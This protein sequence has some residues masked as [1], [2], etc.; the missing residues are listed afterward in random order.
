M[1][2]YYYKVMIFMTFPPKL[3][4]LMQRNKLIKLID[5]LI[6][7]KKKHL[8]MRHLMRHKLSCCCCF[9]PH[10][11]KYEILHYN[12]DNFDRKHA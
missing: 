11:N 8:V 5:N 2:V 1:H 7:I 4:L 12:N 10:R 9:S 6:I 3:E